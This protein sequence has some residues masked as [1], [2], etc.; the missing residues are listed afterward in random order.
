MVRVQL[1]NMKQFLN[2]EQLGLSHGCP[3]FTR[4]EPS[5]FF[6]GISWAPISTELQ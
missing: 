3:T 6:A 5:A 1:H 4:W 2:Y